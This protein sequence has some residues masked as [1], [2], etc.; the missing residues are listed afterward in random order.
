MADVSVRP[1]RTSDAAAIA[2]IQ[3]A[4]WRFAFVQLL[5]SQVL[6]MS[7]DEIEPL[8]HRSI[9]AAPSPRHQVYVATEGDTTVGFAA[10]SP[11]DEDEPSAEA[12]SLVLGPILVEPRWGR[13][14]H[15]SRLLAAVADTAREE[16][17]SQLLCW[18]AEADAVSRSFLTSAGWQLDGYARMLAAQDRQLREIRLHT[19]LDETPSDASAT[20]VRP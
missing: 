7:P 3:L 20:Q 5:P 4:V 18:L 9:S 10:C 8:W 13:R 2:R 11:A 14:G 16:G 15:G 17:T 6:S 12:T 1:A 19:R